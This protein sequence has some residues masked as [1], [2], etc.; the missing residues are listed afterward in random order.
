MVYHKWPLSQK[1]NSSVTSTSWLYGSVHI[2][3]IF[4]KNLNSLVVTFNKIYQP[5]NGA[6]LGYDSLLISFRI[7]LLTKGIWPW[8][9]IVRFD[10]MRQENK[11][12]I[13]IKYSIKP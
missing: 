5:N 8:G 9:I 3:M 1:T 4:S 12:A 13:E 10:F 6:S 7:R 11:K 2:I